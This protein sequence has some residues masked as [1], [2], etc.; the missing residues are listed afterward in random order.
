MLFDAMTGAQDLSI[1]RLGKKNAS[2]VEPSGGVC[3]RLDE[4]PTLLEERLFVVRVELLPNMVKVILD[5]AFGARDILCGMSKKKE[6]A[7]REYIRI[8][9]QISSY[10]LNKSDTVLA[11]ELIEGGYLKGTANPDED[12]AAVSAGITGITV[13]G[14]LFLQKLRAEEEA[15]S[16]LGIF[17]KYGSFLGGSLCGICFPIVSEFIKSWLFP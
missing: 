16:L 15:E 10:P 1:L 14:R 11:G 8:L 3:D 5:D 12:G 17:K 6:T 7:R 2:L 4:Q 9:A 13:Q